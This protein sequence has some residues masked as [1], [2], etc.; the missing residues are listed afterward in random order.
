MIKNH[1]ELADYIANWIRDYVTKA[2]ADGVV[3]GLSGGIDSALVALLC[4][5]GQVQVGCVNV[6][7]PSVTVAPS[8]W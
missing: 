2:G 5:R 1:A 6:G 8:V 7:L 4:R 3:L